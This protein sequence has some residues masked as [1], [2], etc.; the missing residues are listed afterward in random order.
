MHIAGRG[1]TDLFLLTGLILSIAA[2]SFFTFK[3]S[4]PVNE[5]NLSEQFSARLNTRINE[6]DD[7]A[8]RII[9][10]WNSSR[11]FNLHHSGQ[12]NFFTG[13]SS[14]IDLWSDIQPARD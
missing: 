4:G 13:S 12:F 6:A 11:V 5:V 10:D 8:D 9:A 7:I 3:A 1:R 2:C 14:E